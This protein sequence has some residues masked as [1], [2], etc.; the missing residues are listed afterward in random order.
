MLMVLKMRLLLKLNKEPGSA[1]KDDP[2]ALSV[3]LVGISRPR[4]YFTGWIDI[5]R[6]VFGLGGIAFKIR[7][8]KQEIEYFL[9]GYGNKQEIQ[10][11][12]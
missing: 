12:W 5:Q 2:T 8:V 1:A 4:L 7:T 6:R 3:A 9:S 10:T 11:Q